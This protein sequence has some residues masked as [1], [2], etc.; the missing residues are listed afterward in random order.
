MVPRAM[1]GEESG[2]GIPTP[3]ALHSGAPESDREE[4]AGGGGIPP[5]PHSGGEDDAMDEPLRGEG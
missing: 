5:L 2:E 4:G 1:W 3:P